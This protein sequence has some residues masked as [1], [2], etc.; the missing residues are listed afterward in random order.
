MKCKL[1]SALIAWTAIV[2]S[3]TA[4]VIYPTTT[5]AHNIQGGG[6]ISSLYDN[7]DNGGPSKITKPDANDPGTWTATGQAWQ[8]D[9][10]GWSDLTVAEF[11]KVGW[12]TFDFGSTQ[13]LDEIFIWNISEATA[14]NRRVLTYNI[15]YGNTPTVA[16]VSGN[17]GNAAGSVNYDFSSGGWT[18][19]GSTRSLLQW[20]NGTGADG[21]E[22]LGV[23]AR[24]VGLA[25]ITHGG[26]TDRVGLN[27]VVFT[28]I[29]EPSATLLGG[30]GML[31]LLRRRR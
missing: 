6:A 26:S 23:S 19:L 10:Q 8:D 3:S 9:W 17:A 12:V 24:Y 25:F 28:T 30:L 15:Y 31:A 21:I 5:H 11:G 14:Q 2:G 4:A 20:S 16:P 13:Q 22:T 7:N 1:I 29:P 27:E 18:Q